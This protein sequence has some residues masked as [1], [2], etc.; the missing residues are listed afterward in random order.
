MRKRKFS[1][2]PSIS[3]AP[4]VTIDDN[5]SDYTLHSLLSPNKSTNGFNDSDHGV[6]ENNLNII[7]EQDR[8]LPIG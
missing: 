3:Q 1:D 6:S 8:F 5:D 2:S 7:L 4:V